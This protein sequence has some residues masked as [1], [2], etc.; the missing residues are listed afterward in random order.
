MRDYRNGF[1]L[2]EL[3]I[4]IVMIGVLAT[5][6]IAAVNPGAQFQKA[7]DARRKS[8]LSQIQKAIE[9]YYEDIGEYPESTGDHKIKVRG[10]GAV[11]WGGSWLPY[12]G[13]LPK[14]PNDPKK[15]YIYVSTGQAYR[16]YASLD[17]G[18][19]ADI[20]TCESAVGV[21]CD[22]APAQC[23]PGH[24]CTYGISSPNVSP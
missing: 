11:E 22:N 20:Q 3:L 14:D 4:V 19:S 9:Q 6:G 17:R 24:D 15:R 5:M 8:D 21:K 10:G 7:Q 18:G 13:N 23:G 2:I 12:M 1:T 16:L